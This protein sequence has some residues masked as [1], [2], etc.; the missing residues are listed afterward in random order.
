MYKLLR[1]IFKITKTLLITLEQP[2]S[3]LKIT[4]TAINPFS[5]N[6]PFNL[7]KCFVNYIIILILSKR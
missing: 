3:I 7:P 2:I 6:V 1:G 4:K 5:T